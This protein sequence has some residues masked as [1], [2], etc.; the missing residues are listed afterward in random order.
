MFFY[1]FYCK[2]SKTD[3]TNGIESKV[4]GLFYTFKKQVTKTHHT[5]NNRKPGESNVTREEVKG[6][7][8]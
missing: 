4:C 5:N 8:A 6:K 2:C 7:T 1:V 3:K